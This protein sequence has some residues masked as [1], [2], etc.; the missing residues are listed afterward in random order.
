MMVVR[1]D[2]SEHPCLEI[3][4]EHLVEL[5]GQLKNS[6]ENVHLAVVDVGA[7]ARPSNWFMGARRQGNLSI[8]SSLQGQF[9]QVVQLIIVVV[10]A[11]E[12]VALPVIHSCRV[13][14]SDARSCCTF[15]LNQAPFESV[16][17]LPASVAL[18]HS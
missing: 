16:S 18:V 3:V 12:D 10:L 8:H 17:I 13:R 6:S 5:L 15:Y 9:P 14:G 4:N 2:G 11:S 7:V 1:A